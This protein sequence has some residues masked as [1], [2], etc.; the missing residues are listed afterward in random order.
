MRERL[1]ELLIEAKK[2]GSGSAEQADYLLKNGVIVPPCKVGNETFL[3]LERTDGGWD[4]IES[5]CVRVVDNG[6]ERVYSM[7]FDCPEIGNTLEFALRDF[8]KWVFLTR[9]EAEQ[10][11][12]KKER[13]TE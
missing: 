13:D 11:L 3:L 5:K 9:E 6:C 2:Q 10:A 8:G 7:A 4:I 12:Q 1:I